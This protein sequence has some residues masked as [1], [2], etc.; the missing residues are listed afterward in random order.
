MGSFL[1]ALWYHGLRDRLHG[2]T[3]RLRARWGRVRAPA[4]GGRVVW[5]A[6]GGSRESV[7]LGVALVRAIRSRRL[8]IR[9]VLTFERE[10][11]DLVGGLADSPKTGWGYGA[12]DHPRAV[13]RMLGRLSPLGVIFVRLCPR[14]HL[15]R[16]VG[17]VPH[18]LVIDADSP[19][20][21]LRAERIYPSSARQAASWHGGMRAPAADLGTLLTHAQVEPNFKSLINGASFRHLWWFHGDDGSRM[22]ALLQVARSHF[23]DD[24]FFL[25]GRATED[26]APPLLPLSRWERAMVPGGSVLAVDARQWLP[27]L[28]ASA[29]GVHFE[30][31]EPSLLWAALAGGCAVSCADPG[32][33]P[34]PA[35]SVAVSWLAGPDELMGAWSRYRADPILVRGRGDAA[36]R[37]FWEERRLAGEVNEE[38]LE[39]IFAWS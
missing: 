9:L 26:F 37:A 19:E 30:P 35:L 4:A 32:C 13:S 16:A 10:F 21:P 36:R 7:G 3:A 38:L 18:V 34:K 1:P 24:V 23:P 25:S 28:A 17:Q 27:A 2:R 29:T 5:V 12:C 20:A 11:P 31:P 8:D 22:G 6:A 15:A 39:R 14:P 33:L